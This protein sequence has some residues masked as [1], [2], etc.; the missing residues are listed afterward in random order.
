LRWFLPL[1][2]TDNPWS[3]SAEAA[4]LRQFSSLAMP[5]LKWSDDPRSALPMGPMAKQSKKYFQNLKNIFSRANFALS[6]D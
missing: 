2:G 4:L 5:G 1:A 3:F 6:R